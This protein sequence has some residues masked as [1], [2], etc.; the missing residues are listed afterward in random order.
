DS[1]TMACQSMVVGPLRAPAAE[2]PAR[3][4]PG[5]S[6]LIAELSQAV[7]FARASWR[8]SAEGISLH[9]PLPPHR[10]GDE[11]PQV[12]RIVP[13]HRVVARGEFLKGE[14]RKGGG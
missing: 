4:E 12:L 5:C 2:S 8:T 13:P 10:Q 11:A 14:E 7:H 6:T 3:I 1:L 9:A